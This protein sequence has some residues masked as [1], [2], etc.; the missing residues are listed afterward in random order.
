MY[1][2]FIMVVL[3]TSSLITNSLAL[4]AVVLLARTL[5]DNTWWP[6]LYF[7]KYTAEIV[8]IFLGDI[9]FVLVITTRIERKEAVS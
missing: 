7:Q 3:E 1:S 9:T 5:K 4:K 2:I 8:C 6:S